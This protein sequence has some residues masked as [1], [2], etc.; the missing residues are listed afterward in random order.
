MNDIKQGAGFRIA[1]T[2]TRTFVAKSGK[3]GKVSVRV[4]ADGRKKTIEA[5]AFDAPVLSHIGSLADGAIVE[6]TGGVDSEKVTDKDRN[7]VQ[8]GG[9][10]LWVP[11]LTAKAIKVLRQ[12]AQQHFDPDPADD[13]DF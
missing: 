7:P 5:R 11:A 8:V 1:G 2:V 13:V 10:D 9:R 6:I 4:E 12:P 3:F